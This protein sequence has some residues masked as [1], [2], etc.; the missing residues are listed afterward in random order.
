MRQLLTITTWG[1][2]A[3][4]LVSAAFVV[5][6]R[7]NNRELYSVKSG[8][9]E[10]AISVGD[11]VVVE[12][13]YDQLLRGDVI[14]YRSP[15]NPRM[16]ITHR[17][18]VVDSSRGLITAKG[19]NAPMADEPIREQLVVGKVAY[20]VPAVGYGFDFL[21]HPIG[22]GVAVYVP[23]AIIALGEIRKL[24]LFYDSLRRYRLYGH[25]RHYY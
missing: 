24:G 25:P 7:Q 12:R 14:S 11:L 8:S 13:S 21:R 5:L 2:M 23:A 9:M 10:P 4:L 1:V 6:L 16:L 17:V 15:D 18:T 20:A 22:L 3:V 19:D